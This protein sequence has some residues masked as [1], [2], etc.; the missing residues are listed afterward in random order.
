MI[1][2]NSKAWET[3]KTLWN[4]Q[5]I[6]VIVSCLS[7]E[8]LYCVTDHFWRAM[9]NALNDHHFLCSCLK[10]THSCIKFSTTLHTTLKTDSFF[11]Y[12]YIYT[13]SIY[14]MKAKS[15]SKNSYGTKKKAWTKYIFFFLFFWAASCLN[16]KKEPMEKNNFS[17][18]FLKE[19]G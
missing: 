8:T 15:I 16:H 9:W 13:Y 19:T 6:L 10:L 11:R 1:Q 4:V 3:K 14:H 5:Y 17:Q 2:K 7:F 12:I 18:S